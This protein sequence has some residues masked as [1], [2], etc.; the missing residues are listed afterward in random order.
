MALAERA[1]ARISELLT[2]PQLEPD[3]REALAERVV[4]WT[5]W[6]LAMLTLGALATV[7]L[8]SGRSAPTRIV[9]VIIVFVMLL[10]VMAYGRAQRWVDA[11]G[12]LCL[13]LWLA[14]CAGVLINS[15]HAPVFAAGPVLLALVV[16]VFGARWGVASGLSL[17]VVAVVAL[18]LERAG[19]T[20]HVAQPTGG[21]RVGL[22]GVYM[23]FAFVVHGGAQRLLTDA[24][25]EARRERREAEQARATEAAA[26]RA[27]HTVFD[28]ASVGMLLLTAAG[29]VERMND[30]A[31]ALLAMEERQLVGR[32]L[33]AANIWNPEQR[34]L[35]RA[36]VVQAAAGQRSQHELAVT[37]QLGARIIYQLRLSPFHEPAG[38][39]GH[40]LAELID[41][42]DLMAT[43]TMLAQA[44]RLEALG[45]LSGGVAHDINNMLS[46]ILGGSELVR[47][48][49]RSAQVP[50]VETGLE[51]VESSVQRASAL[52][53]Q[54]LAFG[55]QDRFDSSDV[56]VNR[57]VVDMGRLFERTLHKNVSVQAVPSDEPAHARGDVAALENALLNLALNA[58]DAMPSGGTLRIEVRLRELDAAARERMHAP[59]ELVR[60]VVLQVSDTG[61]GMSDAVRERVFEPFFTTKPMGRG[62]GLGLAAVHGTVR[63]H[64]GAIEVHS[65]QGEGSCFELYLPAIAPTAELKAEAAARKV[66]RLQ[67]RVLLADDE[68]LVRRMLTVMLRGAGCEVQETVDGESLMAALAAGAKPDVIISDMVMPGLSGRSLIQ[69]LEATRPGCPLLLITGYTGEDVSAALTG[70]SPHRV[71]RKPF[72]QAELLEAI[73]ELMEEPVRLV[74]GRAQPM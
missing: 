11:A 31:A 16:Q 56:D 35:V 17:L 8:I 58:Q 3:V 38:A 28:Q 25:A 15:V 63:N 48:G 14:M 74:T 2:S 7:L 1:R 52:T 57:L 12:A 27:F 73:Q 32:P 53:K 6:P 20:L 23:A 43:R 40:V 69:A 39:V 13:T 64:H 61:S 67:A 4:R 36:A 10:V 26:E 19:W 47:E 72:V 22:Y 44:R 41:L 65:R 37:Q 42:T 9:P 29:D 34:E 71:L 68:P 30:C 55:R 66:M 60:V 49:R 18:L 33:S 62:T 51:M 70:R 59:Q 24:L 54:L 45:T 21:A 5:T 50:M 46:A